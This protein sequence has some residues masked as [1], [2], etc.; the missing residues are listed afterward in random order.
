MDTRAFTYT[1]DLE[2]V[3]KR[4]ARMMAG[5]RPPLA[6][7]PPQEFPDGDDVRWSPEHLYLAAIQSCTMLSF[8]AHCSHNDLQLLAYESHVEGRLARGADDGRYAFQQVDMVVLARMA[9]GHAGPARELTAKAERDCFISAS[10]T[11]DVVVDW[12]IIE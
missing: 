11:A 10:T 7:T 8:I 2:W 12:R 1:T 4:E 3:G 5:P 9:G 6:V